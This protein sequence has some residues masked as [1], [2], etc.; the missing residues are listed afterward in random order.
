MLLVDL[1]SD[2]LKTVT[3]L[4]VPRF[5]GLVAISGNLETLAGAIG[6]AAAE[7]TRERPAWLEVTVA[8]DD[9]LSDLPARI[10]K[11]TEGWPV[12][13][14]THPPPARQR[15]RP[16]GSRRQRDAGRTRPVRCLRPAACNRRNSS[17]DLQAALNDRYR[18]IVAALHEEE[19]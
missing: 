18:A 16:P 15:R 10:E 12:E 7:G 3:V 19:A 5:Q 4:P 9:Y 8:D 2:G 14:A 17:D 11:M 13:V 6:A 1:D